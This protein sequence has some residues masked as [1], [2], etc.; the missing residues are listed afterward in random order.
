MQDV[1]LATNAVARWAVRFPEL[2]LHLW[3]Q[4]GVVGVQERQPLARRGPHAG[5]AGSSRPGVG[6][7]EQRYL[8]AT[9]DCGRV[10]G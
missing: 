4:P 1:A 3:R 8:V 7:A 10:V 9:G 5:V 6:L 2:P